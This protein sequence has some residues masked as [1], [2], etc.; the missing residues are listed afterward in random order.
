MHMERFLSLRLNT[1]PSFSGTFNMYPRLSSLTQSSI[2]HPEPFA[3][4]II[5]RSGDIEEVIEGLAKD[6]RLEKGTADQLGP[7]SVYVDTPR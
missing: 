4:R 1:F 6:L 7:V 3:C 2:R 5:P